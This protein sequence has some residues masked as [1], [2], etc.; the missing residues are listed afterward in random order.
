M[1]NRYLTA[2]LQP[3]FE[4]TCEYHTK[5]G[6]KVELTFEQFLQLFI[7]CNL[8]KTY[9][10]LYNKWSRGSQRNKF[11]FPYVLTW[12]DRT[13]IAEGIVSI[14]TMEWTTRSYSKKNVGVGMKK[15]SKHT[16][17]AIAKIAA[18]AKKPR[19]ACSAEKARKISVA[20][21][22]RPTSPELC[23]KRKQMWAQ[24][25][26]ERQIAAEAAI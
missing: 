7:D 1:C 14:K 2:T 6:R 24:K 4:K 22:G 21:T 11:S 25:R 20:L 23:A 15:G 10:K 16:P 13:F 26:L 9:F 5:K 17:E 3:R 8:H 18:A 12:R 19:K